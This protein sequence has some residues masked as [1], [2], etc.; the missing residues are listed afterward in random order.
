MNALSP[1]L[2]FWE[3]EL[4]VYK[5]VWVSNVFGSFVQPL[6]YLI[7]MGIGVGAL[8]DDGAGSERLDGLSYIAF[9]GPA[10]IVVTAMMLCAGESLWAVMAGFKW[11]KFFLAAAATPLRPRDI[12]LGRMLW[13]ATRVLI[14][15]VGVAVSLLFFDDTRSWGLIGGIG[16]AI[17]TGL[18]FSMPLHAWAA[19]REHAE[20]FP[21]VMRFGII[22]MF[23]FGGAFYPVSELPGWLE[24]IALATPL[25]HGVSLARGAVNGALGGV[26]ALI[27]VAVLAAYIGV[28]YLLAVK[29]FERRLHA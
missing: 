10:V 24:P 2:R 15:A 16:A 26:E 11:H 17:L 14:G 27:H 13:H 7:G 8:I 28:G 1:A 4:T 6:L 21:A 20:S 22:P 9:F 5:R 25:Y 23:L 18:A 12:V 3:A 19:T 29:M